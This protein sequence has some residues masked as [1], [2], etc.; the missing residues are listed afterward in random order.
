MKRLF[1][2]FVL[3]VILSA[4]AFGDIRPPD[5]PKPKPTPKGKE[6]E[7]FIDV[8]NEVTEPTLVIKKS[9]SKLLRAALDEAESLDETTAQV[10]VEKTAS[11]ASTQTVFGGL[12]LTLGFIFGGV[13]LARSKPSKTVIGLF[14]VGIFVSGTVLVF[15]NIAPPRIFGINKNMFAEQ[16]Q[17]RSG[18]N[19]R[20]KVR[21]KIVN[22]SSSASPDMKLLVPM[23]PENNLLP[24]NE[25]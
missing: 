6:V 8:T 3:L 25:E 23:N 4:V 19:A 16:F 7:M 1:S 20:G 9:S 15:A 14:L 18:A 22:D 11:T 2:L 12:F 17:S 10:P 24:T 5:T 13:W 21:V